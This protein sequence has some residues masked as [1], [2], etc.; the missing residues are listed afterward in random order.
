MIVVDASVLIEV[1]LQG[2]LA[3][4]LAERFT[5]NGVTLHAPHLVDIEVTHVLRRLTQA[6]RMEPARAE[7]ALRVLSSLGLERYPH[8]A[9][10][11]R[12]WALRHRVSAYDACYVA[13]AQTLGAGLLTRDGR[14]AKAVGQ[15]V[16][17]TLV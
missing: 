8:G 2:P 12:V 5:A 14:L 6:G 10:L 13:L 17:V 1:L 4:S 11:E 3:A 16:R 9:L 15:L 7:M